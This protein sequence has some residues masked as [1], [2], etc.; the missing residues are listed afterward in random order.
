MPSS[1]YSIVRY[2]VLSGKR[3]V[4]PPVPVREDYSSGHKRWCCLAFSPPC[5]NYFCRPSEREVSQV[6]LSFHIAIR[7]NS[8]HTRHETKHVQLSLHLITLDFS[9][10]PVRSRHRA[11]SRSIQHGR[12]LLL[13]Y[14]YFRKVES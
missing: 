7:F 9:F 2:S 11:Q 5:L 12:N 14:M 13:L 4:V 6:L 1:S 3:K 10:Y 8:I